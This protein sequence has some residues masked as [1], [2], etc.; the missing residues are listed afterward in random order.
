MKKK[1]QFSRKHL[2]VVLIMVTVI[3]LVLAGIC[4]FAPKD[5][6]QQGE[7]EEQVGFV[8]TIAINAAKPVFREVKLV[9]TDIIENNL[10]DAR[11]RIAST[12]DTIESVR[13]TVEGTT[14]VTSS[15]SQTG[16]KLGKILKLLDAADMA[17]MEIALP[18]TDLLEEYPISELKVGDGFNTKLIGRYLDFAES[19][20]PKVET[21]LECANSVNL[22]ELDTDGEVTEYLDLANKVMDIYHG[23]EAI[24][25][26]IRSMI[27]AEEDRLYVIAVQNSS[28]VRAS[29]GF[30]GSIGTMRIQ[31]GVLTLG[32]FQ[33]VTYM[34]SSRTPRDIQITGEERALFGYLS[35]IQ[36]PRDA[37]L[38]PDFE[39]VGHI[40][41]SAYEE[42]NKEPVAGV[43]SMTPHI[44]QRILAAT[45]KTIELFDGLVL[46]GDNAMKVLLHDIYFKYFG[47]EYVSGRGK[48]S[49]ELFADAA[50]K[51]MKMLTDNVSITQLLEYAPILKDSI[52]DRTLMVWM[53]DESEQ[54]FITRMGWSGGLNKDPD[55]PEAGVYYNCIFASKMGWY[56]L[57]DTEIGD[58]TKN[59][60]GSYTYPVT[61]TFANNATT[62]EIKAAGKYI[63]G[64]LGGSFRGAAYFFAPAGG[65][66]SDFAASNGQKIQIKTYNGMELGFTGAFTLKPDMPITVTYLVTTAPGVETPLAISQTPTAQ[67]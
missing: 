29:G 3:V 23:E 58:R 38:C 37:D 40:W 18:A 66:V 25:S 36:T 54:Q 6:T 8:K 31:E 63:I 35:G 52:E 27:G 55:N 2:S 60:D 24:F 33:S 17:L 49:D 34:L 61:V 32:D 9:L 43:I 45:G 67:Q 57:A 41:A 7:N 28:E 22:K 56:F 39:R 20:M 19:V 62:E 26:M 10:D 1:T 53:K 15:D 30:P 42:M 4:S 51:T 50:K 12:H 65:T 5:K 48:T 47:K 46:D 11:D 59:E 21:V 14:F 13:R 16:K 64:D 44:V